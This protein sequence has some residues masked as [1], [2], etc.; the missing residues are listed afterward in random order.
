[1]EFL[2]TFL[3]TDMSFLASDEC[4][5]A[6]ILVQIN[7]REGLAEDMELVLE[8]KVFKHKLD[9]EGIPFLCQH[10]H[11]QGNIANQ[12]PL[13]LRTR[14][15]EVGS[16]VYKGEWSALTIEPQKFPEEG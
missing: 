12:F 11:K 16:G 1:L 3:D 4:V 6:H 10:F 7:L 8:G 15:K 5:V 13:L 2:G 9:Y 14:Q